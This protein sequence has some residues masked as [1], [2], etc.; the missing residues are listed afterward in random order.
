MTRMTLAHPRKIYC[1]LATDLSVFFT[2][3]SRGTTNLGGRSINAASYFIVALLLGFAPPAIGQEV[4]KLYAPRPPA[5][6]AFVRVARVGVGEV[7]INDSKM[8]F[9]GSNTTSRYR[10]IKPENAVKISVDGAAI[11]GKIV[12]LPDQFST[13]VLLQTKSGLTSYVVEEGQSNISDLKVQLRFFNLVSG[14]QA[15][16]K[17]ADGPS[18]FDATAINNVRSR[19]INP[20][21]ATVQAICENATTSLS[22]PALHAGDHFSLFLI[23]RDGKLDLTGQF[24][25]TEPYQG[26]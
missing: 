9:D 6:Y 17:V 12:P 1:Q 23:D 25:E 18:I 22:L 2:S 19:A 20:V 21:Q 8:Q 26:F 5:G 7:D 14:C 24:D 10:A 11:G 4:G 16:L 15:S 13:I 3:F